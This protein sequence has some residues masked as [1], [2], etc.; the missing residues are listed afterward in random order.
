MKIQLLQD[1]EDSG[2]AQPPRRPPASGWQRAPATPQ[3]SPQSTAQSTAQTPAQTPTEGETTAA[4]FTTPAA[5]PYFASEPDWLVEL[6]RQDAERADARRRA[7]QWRRRVFAWTAAAGVLAALA[8]GGFWLVEDRRV[9]GALVVV[10][11]TTPPALATAPGNAPTAMKVETEKTAPPAAASAAPSL[12][13]GEAIT[14][15]LARVP[16]LPMFTR[17]PP[18]VASP[19]VASPVAADTAASAAPATTTTAADASRERKAN[20]ARAEAKQAADRESSERHRREETLLQC[21]ALGYDEA[22]C[23]KRSCV[24][25][26]FGLACRG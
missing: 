9:D 21:R 3:S 1:I 19:E 20:A 7:G 10:A 15:G 5:E 25:T 13:T 12:T 24:M 2:A 8:A 11:E 18:E 17:P 22:Q 26:R 23:V 6:M 16:A 14:P 4:P